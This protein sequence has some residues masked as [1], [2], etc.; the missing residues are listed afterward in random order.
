M[1]CVH[2]TANSGNGLSQNSRQRHAEHTQMKYQHKGKV[3]NYI[4]DTGHHQK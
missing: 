4:Y 2:D 1:I 3:Q